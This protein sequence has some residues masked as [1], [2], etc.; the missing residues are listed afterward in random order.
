MSPDDGEVRHSQQF[1]SQQVEESDRQS[2]WVMRGADTAS[3]DSS[4][5]NDDLEKHTQDDG[6]AGTG[7]NKY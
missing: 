5:H 1:E 6:P 3:G 7:M 4:T 2:G